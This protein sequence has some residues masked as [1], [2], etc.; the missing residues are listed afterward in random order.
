MATIL[1][2]DDRPV[3]RELL[4]TLLHYRGHQV[5]EAANGELALA[6]VREHHPS[7]VISDVMMPRMDGYELVRRIR[8]DPTIARTPV[9]FYSATYLV[10]EL[11]S[12]ADS[13]GVAVLTKPS[14]PE[15]ILAAVDHALAGDSNLVQ[16]GGP[17]FEEAHLR[18]LTDKLVETQ[19]QLLLAIQGSNT[20]IWDWDVRREVANFSPE[21]N[22][23]IGHSQ[24]EV[25]PSLATWIDRVHEDDRSRVVD[26]IASC[27]DGR[28]MTC[29]FEHRL[30]H[31]D[32]SHRW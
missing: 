11:E 24:A 2:A 13:C 19:E 27:L 7:L 12:L 28:A 1:I 9:L 25:G 18:L 30:R 8:N 22:S 14:E 32:G 5:L 23:M 16:G 29:E 4:T 17:T 26:T 20:A 31:K 10:H 3:D 15:V 6:A 21:W